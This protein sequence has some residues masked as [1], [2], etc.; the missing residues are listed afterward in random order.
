[1]VHKITGIKN[2]AVICGSDSLFYTVADGEI[3]I[4]QTQNNTLNG[5]AIFETRMSFAQF[6]EISSLIAQ[7]IQD[8]DAPD[9]YIETEDEGT[10]T[11]NDTPN[12]HKGTLLRSTKEELK[13]IHED[14]PENLK[15]PTF[16]VLRKAQMVEFLMQYV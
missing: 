12:L 3:Y 4:K 15:D 5:R 16:N 2:G 13:D 14:L 9:E 11:K 7:E 10:G 6:T 8:Y 1:M